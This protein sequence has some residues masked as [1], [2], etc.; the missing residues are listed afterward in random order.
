VVAMLIDDLVNA[1]GVDISTVHILGH[2][3]GSHVAGYAGERLKNLGRIT[4]LDPAG[5]YFEGLSPA[6]RLDPTD[7]VFVDAI[8]T[9]AKH[10]LPDLGFGMYETAGHVDFY[11]NGGKEQP[12]CDLERFTSIFTEGLVEEARRLVACNHQRAIDFYTASLN[13]KQIKPV[14]YQCQDYASFLDGKCTDCGTD[15]EKC[16]ILGPDAEMWSKFKSINAGQRYFTATGGHYPYFQFEYDV[17]IKLAS[18]HSGTEHGTMYITLY[19]Q[20]VIAETNLNSEA[21]DFHQGSTYNFILRSDTDFGDITSVTFRWHRLLGIILK[22][23]MY[24]ESIT[25]VPLTSPNVMDRVKHASEIKVF[26]DKNPSEGV[27]NEKDVDFNVH[28]Q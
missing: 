3:L 27:E 22:S 16:A 18:D 15:G 25:V 17:R 6:A 11:P 5:P 14:S 9:D 19:G 28:C 8:H 24:V 4:G 2:S 21:Q 13:H 7:A 23:K 10:L 1:T 12:G 20:H 26:C